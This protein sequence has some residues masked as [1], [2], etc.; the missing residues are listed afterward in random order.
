[1][2]V[3]ARRLT[4]FARMLVFGAGAVTAVS[5]GTI[6]SLQF[7][8][9]LVMKTWSPLPVSRILDLAG[10]HVPRKYL[11]A[12]VE[13]S[14]RSRYDMQDIVEWFLDLPAI[15][16]LFVALAV[17]ALFYA[18]L[19]SLEKGLAAVSGMAQGLKRP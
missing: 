16:V 5:I 1:V 7:G 2:I 12:G 3:F 11:A 18:S 19:T 9:W 10:I 6:V 14:E 17:L 4:T 15:V 8:F 13:T